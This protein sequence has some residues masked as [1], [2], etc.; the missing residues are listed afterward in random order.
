MKTLPKILLVASLVSGLASFSF[1]GPGFQFWQNQKSAAIQPS[2]NGACNRMLT[3]NAG[4]T[5][6]KTPV[7]S[8]KCTPELM[9][10]DSLCQKSCGFPSAPSTTTCTHMLVRKTGSASGR[11]PLVSVACTPELKANDPACQSHCRL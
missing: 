10:S 8:I 7:V 6:H 4:P 2:A 1:A 9:K 11:T 5:A 3:P